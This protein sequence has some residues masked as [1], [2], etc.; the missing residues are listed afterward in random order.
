MSLPL[1]AAAPVNWRIGAF[2]PVV[3]V[4]VAALVR[5]AAC[6]PGAE[7]VA[8]VDPS[9]EQAVIDAHAATATIVDISRIEK[10][11]ANI[12]LPSSEV[13]RCAPSGL[14][15]IRRYE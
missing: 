9:P 2:A 11:R 8:T 15:P 5:L 3:H 10:G 4:L 13:D 1:E 14:N 7:C 12:L 6:D